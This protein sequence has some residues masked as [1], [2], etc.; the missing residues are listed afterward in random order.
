[1][2]NACGTIALLHALCN[3]DKD[4]ISSESLLSRLFAVKESK[5]ND[6]GNIC[7]DFAATDAELEK[8]HHKHAVKGNQNNL[9]SEAKCHYVTY[10]MGK[11][12]HIIELDGR[13][14]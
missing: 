6:D 10:V 3:Q 4:F 2:S 9:N 1:M 14:P 11:E 5:P 7:G 8:I 13:R 12:G